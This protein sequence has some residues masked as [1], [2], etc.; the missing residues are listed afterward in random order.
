MNKYQYVILRIS[1]RNIMK[2]ECT[3]GGIVFFQSGNMVT[4]FFFNSTP[5]Q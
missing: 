2:I 1:K 4:L 5:E 3:L